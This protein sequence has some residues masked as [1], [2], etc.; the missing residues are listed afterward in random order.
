MSHRWAG[1]AAAYDASFAHLCAGTVDDLLSSLEP[2]GAGES[3]LDV[4]CGP[5]T[6][7]AAAAD[8]GFA[9]LGVDA[10][11]SM[12]SLAHRKHRGL[13]IVGGAL[14]HLPFAQ[15]KFD[16]VAA[17]F[18]VNHT[19]DPRAAVREMCRVTRPGGRLALTIWSA[20]PS[21]LN[22]LWNDV[23]TMASVT[24]PT[25]N[26]LPPDR[27]FE[28]TRT[29]LAGLMTGAGLHDVV[30]SEVHWLFHIA[31]DDL[32]RAVAG[33]VATIGQTFQAQPPVLQ[34]GMRDA[35]VRLVDQRYPDGELRLP[36]SALLASARRRA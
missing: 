3:M 30:V 2:P 1:T 28:R 35:Y 36:S 6:V 16:A 7:A 17:N 27:D 14:P 5:G 23:M 15:K 32:W 26:T 25:G 29:G 20:A 9:A 4:G 10:D 13:P 24:P 21:P 19:P 11:E 12:L 31:A 8:A 22:R 34:D 18:V 33:G